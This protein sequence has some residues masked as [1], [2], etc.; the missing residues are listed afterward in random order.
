[1][2]VLSRKLGEQVY[3]GSDI[4][5]SVLEIKGGRVR[6]GV[7]APQSVPVRRSEIRR[8]NGA[9]ADRP[10]DGSAKNAE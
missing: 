8:R 2:L 10:R 6:I 7:S 4:K 3:I 5:V 9:S 1:M